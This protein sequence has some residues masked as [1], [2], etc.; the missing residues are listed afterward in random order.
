MGLNGKT[1]KNA[2][3]VAEPFCH[4]GE[5]MGKLPNSIPAAYVYH[6]KKNSDLRV[7]LSNFRG[8]DALALS[9]AAFNLS[10]CVPVSAS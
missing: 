5:V 10:R 3:A 2:A 9:T 6:E 1:H 7:H 8:L 4:L